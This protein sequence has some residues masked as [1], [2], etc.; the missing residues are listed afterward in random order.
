MKN[1]AFISCNREEFRRAKYA[2][3]KAIS[4]AKYNYKR[5]FIDLEVCANPSVLYKTHII[6]PTISLNSFPPAP[7]LLSS[8][9]IYRGIDVDLH[10]V[11]VDAGKHLL[12]TSPHMRYHKFMSASSDGGRGAGGEGGRGVGSPSMF[13]LVARCDDMRIQLEDCGARWI[14]TSSE[15]IV[16]VRGA[17]RRLQGIKE[18]FSIG[19]ARGCTSFSELTSDVFGTKDYHRSIGIDPKNDVALLLYSSGTT[20]KPKGILR[21]HYTIVADMYQHSHPSVAYSRSPG[22]EVYLAVLPFFH[23]YGCMLFQ[24]YCLLS[25]DTVVVYPR[26]TATSFVNSIQMYKVNVLIIVPPI[27]VDITRRA[28]TIDQ[29]A[30]ASVHTAILSATTLS[31]YIQLQLQLYTGIRRVQQVFG[32]TETGTILMPEWNDASCVGT[33]GIPACNTECK[34][35]DHQTGAKLGPHQDGELLVRGPSV[36]KGYLN[37]SSADDL[38][39]DHWLHTGDMAHYDETGRF[40]IVDRYKQLVKYNGYQVI[41]SYLENLL[42]THPAVADAGVIGV[43]DER[44]GE[45]PGRLRRTESRRDGDGSRHQDLRGRVKTYTPDTSS[46]L[47]KILVDRQMGNAF[48]VISGTA[49]ELTDNYNTVIGT[50]LDKRAPI[51]TRIV[52]VRPKTP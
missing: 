16:K 5:L 15:N 43:P 38:D 11:I 32:M 48:A 25:G 33:V 50:N 22:S 23:A 9:Y 19:D 6:Q 51:I 45:L 13:P 42:L 1:S 39:A 29:A 4:S 18:I 21:T 37:R 17:V 14:V 30:F 34:V 47:S 40:Y 2:V 27:A 12:P 49:V 3:R 44:A 26:Y 24:H 20:G 52:T 46:V 31:P 28:A 35:I 41:P 7:W 10:D 36:M 8:K